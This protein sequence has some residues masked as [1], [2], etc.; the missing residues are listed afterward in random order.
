MERHLIQVKESFDLS[1]CRLQDH[2][3]RSTH[4]R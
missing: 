3:W 4:E 2:M 1:G